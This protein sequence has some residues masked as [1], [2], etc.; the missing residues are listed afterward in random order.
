[1]IVGLTGGIA[2]GKSTVSQCLQTLGL[3]VVDAD[4]I[5]REVVAPH[6]S[7]LA[8]VVDAF[9]AEMLTAAGELDRARMG[10]LIFT[11]P[12]KR[13]QLNEIVH[14][15]VRAEMHTRT[16]LY[17][18]DD[19]QR[20]AVWDVPL[21]FESVTHK[22]VD[23][24]V[25]VYATEKMQLE[26]L[27]HRNQL[28]VDMARQRIRSQMPIESKRALADVVVHNMSTIDAVPRLAALLVEVLMA[29]AGQSERSPIRQTELF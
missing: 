11:D 18:A 7:G 26:R 25:L 12:V 29:G 28:S 2:T 23:V 5:A 4:E 24:T 13:A 8:D 9:G 14:P 3:F 19:P 20:I 6:T 1:M 10:R 21:L 16:A 22:M 27:R 15:R 17:M